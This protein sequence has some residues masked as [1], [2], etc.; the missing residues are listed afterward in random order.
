MRARIAAFLC[1]ALAVPASAQVIEAKARLTNAS[2][3]AAFLNAY[4]CGCGTP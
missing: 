4:T 3:I 1:L 2:D